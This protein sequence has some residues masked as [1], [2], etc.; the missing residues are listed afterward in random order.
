MTE[1]ESRIANIYC[2]VLEVEGA[3]ADDDI[4]ELGGDSLHVIRI[5][6][7][8]QRVFGVE[9][10]PEFVQSQNQIRQLSRWIDDRRRTD[11]PAVPAL[12]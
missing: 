7:E 12:S 1:T 6:L 8:V 3:T 2:A 9:V 10:T 5:A 4:F 11:S